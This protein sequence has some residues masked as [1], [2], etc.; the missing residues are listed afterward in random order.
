MIEKY[1]LEGLTRVANC[2]RIKGYCEPNIFCHQAIEE[3]MVKRVLCA[4]D[5]LVQEWRELCQ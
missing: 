2:D 4:C 1:L 3:W 5:L